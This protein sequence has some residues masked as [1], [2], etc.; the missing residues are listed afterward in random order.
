MYYEKLPLSL[1]GRGSVTVG[2]IM[3]KKARIN[4]SRKLKCF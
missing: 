3:G 2:G 4:L 1:G